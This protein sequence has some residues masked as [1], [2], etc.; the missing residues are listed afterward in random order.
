MTTCLFP[1]F[2]SLVSTEI[3]GFIVKSTGTHTSRRGL[4]PCVQASELVESVKMRNELLAAEGVG[5]A[6]VAR[7]EMRE[8]VDGYS[9]IGVCCLLRVIGGV[10][11]RKSGLRHFQCWVCTLVEGIQK[12]FDRLR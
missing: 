1:I 8:E 5:A 12:G 7:L 10:Q 9:Q 3:S 2:S 4:V 6:L 11:T